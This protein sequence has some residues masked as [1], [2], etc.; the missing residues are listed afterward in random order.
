MPKKP[1]PNRIKTHRVYTTYEAADA[2][3]L[4]RKTIV[5]WITRSGLE[6]DR[7]QRPWLIEGRNLKAFLADRRQCGK[8]RLN[9]GE[10]YCLPCRQARI[11]AGR[12]ADFRMKSITTGVLSGICPDCDHMMNRIIRRSDLD[13]FRAI[14]DVT[15]QKGVAGIVGVSTPFATLPQ[16]EAR[17]S[18]G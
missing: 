11:P 1:S 12:M 17:R 7:S 9:V 3:D 18:H 2:L 5:H 16:T 13:R 4:H 6:A 14:L 8:V 10:I 15:V